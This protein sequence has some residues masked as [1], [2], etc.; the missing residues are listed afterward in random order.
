MKAYDVVDIGTSDDGRQTKY[1][2]KLDHQL[3]AQAGLTAEQI[4]GTLG[5][6]YHGMDVSLVYD[7]EALEP[8][9][10]HVR[11]KTEQIN[12]LDSFSQV[13]ITTPT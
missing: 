11:G 9:V 5:T 1:V 2:V 10:I 7:D 3:I 6:L 8:V 4:A 12:D 13:L